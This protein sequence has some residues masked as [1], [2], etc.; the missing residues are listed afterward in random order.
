MPIYIYLTHTSARFPFADYY[1][2]DNVDSSGMHARPVIGGVFIK[3]LTDPAIWAKWA[4]R[5]TATVGG[6]APFPPQ[7]TITTIIPTSQ[8]TPL[9]WRYTE[10]SPPA[11]WTQTDFDDHQWKTG[12][13]LFGHWAAWIHTPWNSDNIWIRRTWVMPQGNFPDLQFLVFHNEEV[14]I[15]VNGILAAHQPG[16]M[17]AYDVIEIAPAAKALFQPGAQLTIAAHCHRQGW[18]QGIDI[19]L[20]NVTAPEKK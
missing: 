11:Q 13:A 9:I 6:W 1:V 5:D 12:P 3:M 2:T 20:A 17:T 16:E 7:P 18:G 10:K 19:G 8:K 14:E 15:Y 4:A